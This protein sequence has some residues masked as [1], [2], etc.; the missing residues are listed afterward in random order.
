MDDYDRFCRSGCAPH[1]DCLRHYNECPCLATIISNCWWLADI[2]TCLRLILFNTDVLSLS[3]TLFSS[4]GPFRYL[5]ELT[6]TIV[7]TG[8]ILGFFIDCM[9]GRIRSMTPSH[10]VTPMH[11][12]VY[13]L[14]AAREITWFTMFGLLLPR[15]NTGTWPT[16]LQR[17]AW[18]AT[19]SE[20]GP[21]HRWRNPYKRWCR[22]CRMAS[23]R[24]LTPVVKCLDQSSLL[25]HT[26]PFRG[27][28]S[29]TTTPHQPFWHRRGTPLPLAAGP[30]PRDSRGC[31]FFGSQHAADVC[32]GSVQRRTN[33]WL[34]GTSQQIIL[35]AQ[36]RTS[37][38]LRHVCCHG[39][40]VGNGC[41]DDAAALGALEIVSN[42]TMATSSVRHLYPCKELP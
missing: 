42:H 27:H 26:Q 35:Q 15:P 28:V 10:R 19:S 20:D 34:A 30:V 23:R 21:I 4:I 14:V 29:T 24:P 38:T 12:S 18:W 11:C 32:F 22:I 3:S 36:L 16:F 39:G 25:K 1:P 37:H 6:T 7:L 2:P 31:I 17:H 41:A 8:T 13:V 9:Q 33:V 40:N 5:C